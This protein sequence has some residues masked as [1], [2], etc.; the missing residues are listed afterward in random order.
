MV[1]TPRAAERQAHGNILEGLLPG[2]S[3]CLKSLLLHY[4]SGPDLLL[5]LQP[6]LLPRRPVLLLREQS[7]FQQSRKSG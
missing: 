5:Q 1:S 6:L 4:S 2:V 3:A 7:G